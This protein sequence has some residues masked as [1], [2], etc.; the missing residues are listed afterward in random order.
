MATESSLLQPG[1]VAPPFALPDVRSGETR[2]LDELAGPRGTIVV[3]TC[4]HCPYVK[5]VRAGVAAFARDYVPRGV[6]MVGIA[7]NDAVRYP[8]DAPDAIAREADAAG[9]SFPH[10]H[11]AEQTVARA[12]RAACTP[13]F[14]L[15]DA[16]RRLVYHGRFDNTRPGQGAPSGDDLRSATDALLAGTPLEHT[17]HTAPGCGIKWR[18]G[19][20]PD[21]R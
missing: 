20:E 8:D 9:W 6:A 5:H 11:D 16:A 7:A 12:Y 14:Y 13:E 17:G 3:F 18:P 21:Y 2:T 4:N 19:N 1:T 10:L 15:F